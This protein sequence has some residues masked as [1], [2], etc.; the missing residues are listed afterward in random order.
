MFAPHRLLVVLLSVSRPKCT[1]TE[2][3]WEERLH[4][5]VH[6]A[7]KSVSSWDIT[8]RLFY[9]ILP[10]K[11]TVV[12]TGNTKAILF[13]V[14]T[15][16]PWAKLISTAVIPQPITCWSFSVGHHFMHE[17]QLR[18]SFAA[19]VYP[20]RTRLLG[21]RSIIGLSSLFRM[22]WT[23]QC[24]ASSMFVFSWGGKILDFSIR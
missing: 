9:I 17:E 20:G 5:C 22:C 3:K 4:V 12:R 15:K 8:R 24:T 23:K 11:L 18:W 6:T 1:K 16:I 21:S 10:Y 2:E 7:D 14:F 19:L 13:Y